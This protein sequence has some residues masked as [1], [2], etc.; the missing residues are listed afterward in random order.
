MTDE[1]LFALANMALN[2]ASWVIVVCRLKTLSPATFWWIKLE[3]SVGSTVLLVSAFSYLWGGW[4]E[5][6]HLGLSSY[7]LTALLASAPAW[8]AHGKD[9]APDI[10]TDH[11]KLLEH[12][13]D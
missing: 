13:N 9:H 4:P 10:V 1:K 11:A 5:W 2:L 7:V 8:R 6:G 12:P 3:Y